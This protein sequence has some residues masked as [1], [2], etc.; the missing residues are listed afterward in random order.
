MGVQVNTPPLVITAPAGGS[1]EGEGQS[2][3]GK[4]NVRSGG[5]EAQ[6][7]FFVDGLVADRV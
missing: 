4:V 3:G 7:G 6:Q 1:A 2:V 5:G